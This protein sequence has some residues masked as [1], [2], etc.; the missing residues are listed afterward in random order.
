MILSDCRGGLCPGEGC[1]CI[2]ALQDVWTPLLSKVQAGLST[3]YAWSPE[4]YETVL[5]SLLSSKYHAV[6]VTLISRKL[7]DDGKKIV[8]A[9]VKASLLSYR[10][11]S[12]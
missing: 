9:M 4:Q 10:P 12:S 11:P 3:E 8:H 5:N 7:G 2:A 1:A 6:P